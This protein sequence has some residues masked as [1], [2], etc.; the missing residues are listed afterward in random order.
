MVVSRDRRE[1]RMRGV[2]WVIYKMK[3]VT[4]M[5]GGDGYQHCKFT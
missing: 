5:E 4:E 2:K 3:S 1:R